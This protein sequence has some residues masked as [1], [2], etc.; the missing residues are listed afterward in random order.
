[1]YL[2]QLSYLVYLDHQIMIFLGIYVHLAFNS[3]KK[4]YLLETTALVNLWSSLDNAAARP[5]VNK[6]TSE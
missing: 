5:A 4:N 3:R 6:L 2:G 1:M